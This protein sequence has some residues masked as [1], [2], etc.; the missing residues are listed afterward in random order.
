MILEITS[1]MTVLDL[2]LRHDDVSI[3]YL[4]VDIILYEIK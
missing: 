1:V 4:V 2:L 3:I